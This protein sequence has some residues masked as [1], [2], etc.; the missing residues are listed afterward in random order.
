M[1]QN[2]GIRIVNLKYKVHV[3]VLYLTQNR[4]LTFISNDKTA[5]DGSNL[6]EYIL[7]I[8]IRRRKG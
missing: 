5:L 3:H 7:K 4:L 6:T 1:R 8:F 2:I